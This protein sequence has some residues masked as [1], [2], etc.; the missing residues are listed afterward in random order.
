MLGHARIQI[1]WLCRCGCVQG[2]RGYLRFHGQTATCCSCARNA[3][4][5]PDLFNRSWPHRLAWRFHTGHNPT[6]VSSPGK[7]MPPRDCWWVRQPWGKTV[8]GLQWRRVL[9]NWRVR[10]GVRAGPRRSVAECSL[11]NCWSKRGLRSVGWW[12]ARVTWL[13]RLW[14]LW[15]AMWSS[16]AVQLTW[17]C[18]T[19]VCPACWILFQLWSQS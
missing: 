13:L 5:S 7:N 3:Q 11:W 6:W 9:V 18:L 8:H 14:P 2:G 15:S 12:C 10:R 4:G 1:K 19:R 17:C 16:F